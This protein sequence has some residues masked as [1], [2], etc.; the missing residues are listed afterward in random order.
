MCV[1]LIYNKFLV[2]EMTAVERQNDTHDFYITIRLTCLRVIIK[3]SP[4]K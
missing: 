4:S 2:P 1:I 3:F